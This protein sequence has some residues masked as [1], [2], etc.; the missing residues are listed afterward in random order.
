MSE[1]HD[2]IERS[3]GKYEK[4]F[5]YC[6]M[7]LPKALNQ[8]ESARKASKLAG[9]WRQS[10]TIHDESDRKEET[11]D[12]CTKGPNAGFTDEAHTARAER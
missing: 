4:C 1:G 10:V 3:R 12:L 8:V 11:E 6:K 7:N 9:L 5:N 2:Q